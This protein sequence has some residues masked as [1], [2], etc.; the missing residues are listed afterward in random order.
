MNN[1]KPSK[2]VNL[3]WIIY[4][5]HTRSHAI[6][7]DI[8]F[9]KELHISIYLYSTK[10]K[11]HVVTKSLSFLCGTQKISLFVFN[12]YCFSLILTLMLQ[13][14]ALKSTNTPNKSNKKKNRFHNRNAPTGIWSSWTVCI[15]INNWNKDYSKR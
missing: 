15:L 1:D 10:Q 14:Y 3:L 11:I 2:V 7:F 12:K 6:D 9:Q 5:D 8:T 4:I 13:T